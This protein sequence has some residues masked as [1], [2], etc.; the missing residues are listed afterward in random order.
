MREWS[1]TPLPGGCHLPGQALL[2]GGRAQGLLRPHP[3]EVHEVPG[4]APARAGRA[5]AGERAAAGC[6]V[7]RRQEPSGLLGNHHANWQGLRRTLR[8]ER[9]GVPVGGD[10]AIGPGRALADRRRRRQGP[11]RRRVGLW[12]F[13]GRRARGVLRHFCRHQDA[14]RQAQRHPREAPGARKRAPDT[15]AA[16]A[17]P[18]RC[19]PR[20]DHQPRAGPDIAG[21]GACER[22]GSPRL[23]ARQSCGPGR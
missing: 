1:D 18:S 13:R 23:P 12:R 15:A 14:A 21:P 2:R 5:Q 17:S 11:R 6:G 4:G 7:G 22:R 8:W 20:G 19:L 9:R 16:T 3:G 10:R